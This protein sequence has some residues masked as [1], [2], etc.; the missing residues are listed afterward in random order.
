MDSTTDVKMKNNDIKYFSGRKE[1]RKLRT[2]ILG[3]G[4]RAKENKYPKLRKVK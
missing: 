2:E 3:G 4:S 1:I